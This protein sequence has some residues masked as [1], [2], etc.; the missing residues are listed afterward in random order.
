M[1]D[2]LVAR[3]RHQQKAR[4][5]TTVLGMRQLVLQQL[6]RRPGEARAR[7]I[8]EPDDEENEPGKRQHEGGLHGPPPA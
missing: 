7:G 8:D 6:E 3:S 1:R 5:M 4:S 2:Q